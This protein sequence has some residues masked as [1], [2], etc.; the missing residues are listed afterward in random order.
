MLGK[1]Y[2]MDGKAVL[3]LSEVQEEARKNFLEACNKK[4]SVY[5]FEDYLCECGAGEEFFEVLAEKD[6]YGMPLRTVICQ[7]CGMIMTNPRMTQE[8][9]N[10][11][12][13]NIFAKLY[14]GD[15]GTCDIGQ[16]FL[17]QKIHGKVICD[18]VE[19]YGEREIKTVLE[20]GCAAGGILCEFQERGY[21]VTGVD[22]DDE[23]LQYGR[24]KGLDLRLGH[25]SELLNEGKQYDLIILSHVFEHF[26]DIESELTVI[27]DLLTKNGILYIEVP[28]IKMLEEGAYNGNFLAYIQNAHIRNFS[29]GTLTNVMMKYGFELHAGN[30]FIQ[31]LYKYTGDYKT[32][33]SNY[34]IENIDI[35]IRTEIKH[36]SRSLKEN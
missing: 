5:R 13:A 23:Y 22:L 17:K 4:K 12:Y 1:R 9:Y 32:I 10:F 29:L 31:A 16:R 6:R 35:L 30:E 28:G 3:K 18:L 34:Y 33:A 36:I 11:F 24:S 15:D 14:R 27:H 7:K 21:V 19:E 2:L 8:S 26:L 25:S 20:I